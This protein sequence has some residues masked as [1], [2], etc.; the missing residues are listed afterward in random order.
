MDLL[1]T[2]NQ[3]LLEESGSHVGGQ[4]MLMT[5]K[6]KVLQ[7]MGVTP[8]FATGGKTLSPEDMKAEIFVQKTAPKKSAS[9]GQSSIHPELAKSWLK[10]F[11]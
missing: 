1:K 2:P 10:F 3:M 9:K 4:G 8:K 5:P 11:K 6:Q 7:E